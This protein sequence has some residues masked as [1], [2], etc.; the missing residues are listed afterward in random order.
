LQ[1][2]LKKIKKRKKKRMKRREKRKK[3]MVMKKKEKNGILKHVGN[4][5]NPKSKTKFIKT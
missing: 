5:G 2:I 1:G 4:L 3:M